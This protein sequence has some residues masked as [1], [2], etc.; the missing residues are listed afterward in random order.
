[1]HRDLIAAKNV[2]NLL[3]MW[4]ID[5]GDFLLLILT[6]AEC[7]GQLLTRVKPRQ[8]YECV[9]HFWDKDLR[10]KGTSQAHNQ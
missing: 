4:I 1:M 3:E 2:E 7:G 8:I 9:F 10:R 5:E 6:P